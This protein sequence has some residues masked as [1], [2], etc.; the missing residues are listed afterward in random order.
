MGRSR[1]PAPAS[2]E[3]ASETRA[4]LRAS[5]SSGRREQACLEQYPRISGEPDGDEGDSRDPRSPRRH[6]GHAQT[7]EDPD[8]EQER[9]DDRP[10]DAGAGP[11]FDG[12]CHEAASEGTP[13]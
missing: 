2:P 5:S 4:A 13:A 11:G 3:A 7:R 12:T 1:T 9:T 8:G 6:A 10:G